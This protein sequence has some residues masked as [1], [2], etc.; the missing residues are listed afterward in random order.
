MGDE[1]SATDWPLHVTIADTFAVD[2][3]ENDLYAKLANL[4][5]SQPS[6]SITATGDTYL[7]EQT[8][9]TLVQPSAELLRLHTRVIDL[10]EAAGATFNDPQFTRGGF[11]P[12]AT[13]QKKMR[14]HMGEQ[15]TLGRLSVIDMFPNENPYWR[16]VIHL[17][18]FDSDSSR[19]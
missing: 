19:S 3:K 6:I 9:V 12:H 1:F 17:S 18:E 10:L 11:L 8:K 15:H 13:V 2:W 5:Y 4:T 7:G 14:L 16:K